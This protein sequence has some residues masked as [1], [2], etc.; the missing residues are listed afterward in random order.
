[1]CIC[2]HNLCTA[3]TTRFEWFT[4]STWIN[5]EWREDS[6][7][8]PAVWGGG[9]ALFQVLVKW[10]ENTAQQPTLLLERFLEFIS[11][12]LQQKYEVT[13]QESVF[14]YLLCHWW[15]VSCDS[16][17]FYTYVHTSTYTQGWTQSYSLN[18]TF[19]DKRLHRFARYCDIQLLEFRHSS[20][21]ASQ[22]PVQTPV[23]L[24]G[25]GL[26]GAKGVSGTGLA[27]DRTYSR[28]GAGHRFRWPAGA[29]WGSS[30]ACCGVAPAHRFG[31][32][33][34]DSL[35]TG[36]WTASHLRDV[37]W[38]DRGWIEGHTEEDGTVVRRSGGG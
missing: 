17:D 23:D 28:C 33:S 22:W 12:W 24:T 10:W 7:A 5:P 2:L 38:T 14:V 32:I 18:H 15:N 19:Q 25:A 3:F 20:V 31:Q 8:L 1:M 35:A 30:G 34:S 29:W 6:P 26:T 9:G 37:G 16:W 36:S 21:N 4:C 11:S 27:R 13:Y